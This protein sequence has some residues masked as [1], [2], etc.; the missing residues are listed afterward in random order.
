MRLW[1]TGGWHSR[2]TPSSGNTRAFPHLRFVPISEFTALFDHVVGAGQ[3]VA[4]DAPSGLLRP[5][6]PSQRQWLRLC[7]DR[8]ERLA[9]DLGLKGPQPLIDRDKFD[10]RA[11]RVDKIL[12]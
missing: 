2:S 9:T 12:E 7:L 8:G 4:W 10:D 11:P 5:A 1:P 6:G 3:I